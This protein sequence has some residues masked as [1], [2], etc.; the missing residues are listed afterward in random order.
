MIFDDTY[1]IP[2]V[3]VRR[4]GAAMRDGML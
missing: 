4:Y 1:D 3:N 2:S